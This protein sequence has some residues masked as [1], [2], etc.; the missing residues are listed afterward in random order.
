VINAYLQLDLAKVW[1]DASS[2]AADGTQIDTLI[3]NLLAEVRPRGRAVE[4]LQ[5]AAARLRTYEF[6]AVVVAQQ[7]SASSDDRRV[8]RG[9]V[10]ARTF[11]QVCGEDLKAAADRG[12]T[13]FSLPKRQTIRKDGA[14]SHGARS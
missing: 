5:G 9:V 10:R 14:Q 8:A 13:R 1:G 7:S 6:D 11:V 2:V 4:V 3:D 12:L